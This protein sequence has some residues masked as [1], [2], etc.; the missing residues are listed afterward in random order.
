MKSDKLRPTKKVLTLSCHVT[1]EK[2]ITFQSLS[3]F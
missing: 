2:R 3:I 1:D